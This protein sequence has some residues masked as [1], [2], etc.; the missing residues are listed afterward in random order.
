MAHFHLRPFTP[1]LGKVLDTLEVDLGSL[2]ENLAGTGEVRLRFACCPA[3]FVKLSKV[4]IQ[5]ME[6]RCGSTRSN[7]GKRLCVSFCDLP[8][9]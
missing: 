2:F 5:A 8:M 4:D 6:V 3:F 9:V 7:S 1:N